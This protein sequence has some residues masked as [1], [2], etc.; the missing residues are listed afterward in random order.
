VSHRAFLPAAALLATVAVAG[1]GSQS[2]TQQPPTSRLLAVRGS[3]VGKIVLTPLGAHR[4]DLQTARVR[5][6]AFP[7]SSLVTVP[8]SAIVY[9]STGKT[10]VFTR[11][12]HLT[13]VEATVDVDHINGNVAY[14]RRGPRG[15]TDVVSLGAE[16]LF[17]IESGVLQQ[18]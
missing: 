8:T 1:C 17:G 5:A 6:A 16:E 14:L 13:F 9:D 11:H 12:G 18:T 3:S 2:S 7:A 15:G 10:L 4:L